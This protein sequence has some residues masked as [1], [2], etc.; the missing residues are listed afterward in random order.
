MVDHPEHRCCSAT[1][2]L[3]QHWFQYGSVYLI[4]SRDGRIGTRRAG[5]RAG[6]VRL[7]VKAS[8]ATV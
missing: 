4:T 5:G 3:E 6:V 7:R 2:F 8:Y 1:Q